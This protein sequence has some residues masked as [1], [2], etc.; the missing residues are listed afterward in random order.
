MAG[1]LMDE[2]PKPTGI[3]GV[4]WQARSISKDVDQGTRGVADKG[5]LV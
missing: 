1:S 2:V 5:P 3:L 4:I